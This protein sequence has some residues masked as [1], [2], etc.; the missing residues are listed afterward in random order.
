MALGIIALL[1]MPLLGL[2]PRIIFETP[3]ADFS[4][5]KNVTKCSFSPNAS[6]SMLFLQCQFYF[7]VAVLAW[8][9]FAA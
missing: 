7:D 4:M 9:R 5:V 6:R 8:L 3:L 1:F 2:L